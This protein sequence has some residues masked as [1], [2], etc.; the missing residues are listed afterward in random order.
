VK[1]LDFTYNENL[2]DLHCG[3]SPL[4]SL[5]VEKCLNLYRIYLY[6]SQVSVLNLESNIKLTYL[7]CAYNRLQSLNASKSIALDYL[8]CSGNYGL[9][10][11]CVYS[12]EYAKSKFE[13]SSFTE[14]VSV[15]L[16]AEVIFV[17]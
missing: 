3:Y 13:K 10:E 12:V 17:A 11:V 8:N 2:R 9:K 7:N 6:G 15:N 4:T 1:D 5:K 16:L 14:W